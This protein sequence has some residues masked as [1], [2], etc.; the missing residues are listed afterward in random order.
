MKNFLK[1]RN[2]QLLTGIMMASMAFI[3]ACGDDDSEP[4][5]EPLLGQWEISSAT[6]AADVT[7]TNTLGDNLLLSVGTDLTAVIATSFLAN[8]ECTNP[9]AK[10]IE[11]AEGNDI[12][13]VCT[14]EDKSQEAG[15]WSLNG[16]RSGLDLTITIDGN[17]VALNLVNLQETSTSMSGL[18][19]SIPLPPLLL[20]AVEPGFATVQQV[21]IPVSLNMSFRKL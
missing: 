7:A 6:L 13:Y 17:I 19:N 15:S 10:A 4:T 2:I 9:T 12:L 21:A 18:V 11:L 16:D 20:A 3:Y 14:Q 8:I 5:V 1:G